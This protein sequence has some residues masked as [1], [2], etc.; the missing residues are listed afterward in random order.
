MLWIIITPV[1]ACLAIIIG[2]QV[3]V[4][5]ASRG[6]TYSDLEKI[7]HRK[8]ALLLGTNPIGRTGHPNQFFLR[9]ID[10]AVALF[11]KEKIDRI[12][13]S[14]ARTSQSYDEPE[15]MRQTLLSRGVPDSILILDGEGFNTI[16]SIKRA[17][18]VYGADSLTIISQEF[19]NE[20]AIFMA[21]YNGIDAIAYN[22]ANTPSRKWR[23]IMKVLECVSRVKAVIEVIL[24]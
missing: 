22:A 17:K 9:R 14:G 21:K 18:D 12:I 5:W 23:Y 24:K 11:E 4:L 20:R 2:C 1:L 13:I 8:V 3:A 10:A 15:A 16:A 6:R 7:P 19:H